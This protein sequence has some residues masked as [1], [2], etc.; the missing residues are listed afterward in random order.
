MDRF[1]DFRIQVSERILTGISKREGKVE[2]KRAQMK[3]FEEGKL[4]IP[5]LAKSYSIARKVM[6]YKDFFQEFN[7]G[8]FVSALIAIFKSKNYDHKEMMHKLSVC[9]IK[10]QICPNVESYKLLLETIYNHK[11]NKEN[12]V[13][14]RY[15]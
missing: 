14:F 8:T 5:S 6:D 1:P 12:K 13:S 10:L 9:P 11:R 4:S 7:R 2:G 3:D 15:A